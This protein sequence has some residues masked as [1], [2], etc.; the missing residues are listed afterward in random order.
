MFLN[1]DICW[2]FPD[3]HNLLTDEDID[4]NE[5]ERR[6]LS[7]SSSLKFSWM[8]TLVKLEVH[9]EFVKII[10]DLQKTQASLPICLWE[11]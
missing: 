7:A 9:Y 5:L 11:A 3:Q 10:A 6:V 1:S 4:R 2:P 8:I